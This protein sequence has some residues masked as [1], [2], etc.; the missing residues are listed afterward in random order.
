MWISIVA[1][2]N[3]IQFTKRSTRDGRCDLPYDEDDGSVVNACGADSVSETISKVRFNEYVQANS[4]IDTR[5][6]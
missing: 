5:S 2:M 6:E 4:I 3:A 1:M